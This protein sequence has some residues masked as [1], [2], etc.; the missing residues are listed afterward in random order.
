MDAEPCTELVAALQKG[1]EH[2]WD[3]Y[4]LFNIKSL[5]LEG[6]YLPAMWVQIPKLLG[7]F[8][9]VAF[10]SSL[11]IAAIQAEMPTPLDFNSELKTVGASVTRA[12]SPSLNSAI[13][14]R[15]VSSTDVCSNGLQKFCLCG[16]CLRSTIVS[17][18]C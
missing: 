7:L 15:D 3:V 13:V 17:C 4:R 9:V 10:G 11:D 14:V 6:I 1:A 12:P 8:F 18:I 2:F 16:G 5:T